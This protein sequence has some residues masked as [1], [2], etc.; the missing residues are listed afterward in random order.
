MLAA[1]AVLL[2]AFV[3]LRAPPSR[4][5]ADRASAAGEPHLHERDPRRPR[6]LRR[7]RRAAALRL[8]VHPARRRVLTD[9]RRADAPD[10]M[11]LGMLAGMGAGYGAGH[12]ARPPSAPRR[13]RGRRR[14]HR[15]PGADRDRRRTA[16]TLDLA[17][18]LVLI[19]AGAGASIGQLFDFI[20]AGV[21]MDEVGSASGVLEAVQQLA[22]AIGVAA[23]G[24]IF[25]S[26]FADHLP[27]HAWRSP[28]GPAWCR[29]RW[30][31][32]SSSACRCTPA[33]KKSHQ[34]HRP[35]P[36]RQSAAR[37]AARGWL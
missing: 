14:R 3:L 21:G 18:G 9:P 30:R 28:P 36:G 20:L 34:R 27:T 7:V 29:S 17:P 33:S 23:L 5:P 19:G 1:G 31:S 11:V 4:R 25:F 8:A 22:S 6:I 24:T 37:R 26:A 32:R 10:P 2:G 15:R 12:P 13:R 35:S 16:S